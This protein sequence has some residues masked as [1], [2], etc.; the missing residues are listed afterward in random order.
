[1]ASNDPRVQSGGYVA[2]TV[3]A[4]RRIELPNGTTIT[5]YTQHTVRSDRA[6]TGVEDTQGP[7]SGVRVEQRVG[8]ARVGVDVN[9]T[10]SV[11]TAKVER[12]FPTPGALPGSTTRVGADLSVSARGN[13]FARETAQRAIELERRNQR[14]RALAERHNIPFRPQ[15]A[16]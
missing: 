15:A 11:A 2:N 7:Q 12:Q 13:A 4:E 3:G 6:A 14:M 9:D 10:Q 5:P 1:M 8:P 16:N